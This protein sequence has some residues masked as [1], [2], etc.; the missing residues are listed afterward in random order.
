MLKS[1]YAK[2]KLRFKIRACKHALLKEYFESLLPLL[3]SP[4]K[5][6]P[7]L[8][9]DLEMTG[10]N[11]KT[12]QIISIGIMPIIAGQIQ[13]NQGH[14]KLIKIAGSVGQSATIHGVLDTDLQE[15]VTL[16]E[17][18]NWLL[19][20]AVGNVLVAHHAPLDL[21]FISQ[22]IFQQSHQKSQLLAIDTMHIEHKRLLRKQVMINE[23]TLRLSNCRARYNL[24]SYHAHNA[25]IDALSCA[26]LLL[27]QLSKMGHPDKI[28]ISE[29]LR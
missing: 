18:I 25:L 16:D 9:I 14:H 2:V 27:A 24:P 22:A 26:E 23:G 12:N 15:A 20:K 19:K 13:L 3:D 8:A 7:L 4:V 11:A 28:K 21:S 6:V 17:A 10:L 5:S 29:L 1:W